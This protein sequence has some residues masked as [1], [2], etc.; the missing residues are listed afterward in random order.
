MGETL[1]IKFKNPTFE[2]KVTKAKTKAT[3]LT[4]LCLHYYMESKQQDACWIENKF[5]S[6]VLSTLHQF[7]FSNVDKRRNFQIF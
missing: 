6:K 4:T 3:K 5:A 1:M 2:T 7:A